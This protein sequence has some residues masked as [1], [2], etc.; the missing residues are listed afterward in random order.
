[1]QDYFEKV[2]NAPI[3]GIITLPQNNEEILR[4]KLSSHVIFPKDNS[5]ATKKKLIS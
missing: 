4:E 2:V 1:M 3:H 5:S